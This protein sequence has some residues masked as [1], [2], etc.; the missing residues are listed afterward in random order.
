MNSQVTSLTQL[1]CCF[2]QFREQVGPLR[3]AG[4]AT[5]AFDAFGCGSS[6]KPHDPHAYAPGE[7]YADLEAV[8]EKHCKVR[9]VKA[10]STS[11]LSRSL[12]GKCLAA[13]PGSSIQVPLAVPAGC[14]RCL[15][16]SCWND[17]KQS[18]D[19]YQPHSQ[20][21]PP[22]RLVRP[23]RH[24]TVFLVAHSFGTCLAVRLAAALGSGLAGLVLVGAFHPDLGGGAMRG[25]FLLPEM[26]RGVPAYFHESVQL[27]L[28]TLRLMTSNIIML[29]IGRMRLSGHQ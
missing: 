7:L 26:V 12:P 25:L 28:E 11:V 15:A 21:M 17:C 5:V 1:L 29:L 8:Y 4:V 23:Q 27:Q 13:L 18:T 2:A 3:M 14:H 16:L 19:T 22:H 24:R 20:I 6:A 9:K 10:S